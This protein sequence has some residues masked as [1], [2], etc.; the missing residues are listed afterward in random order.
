MGPEERDPQFLI[1]GHYLEKCEDFD[2]AGKRVL[3]SRLGYRISSSFVHAFFGRVFNHPH[4]VFTDEMLRPELQ[5]LDVFADGMD[6][7][8]TTQKRVAEMYFED[9]SIG[10]AC[11]PLR[12]LLH[13]MREDQW[14]GKNLAHPELRQLFTREALLGSDWYAA[15]LAAKQQVDRR[16]WWRHMDYLDRFLKKS[17]YAD[18]AARLGIAGRLAHA[19]KTADEVESPAYLD[20]LRGTL[21]AE[22]IQAY[23]KQ[24]A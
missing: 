22:P 10:Q 20:R 16:L 14:E 17:S 15:R 6:N 18:E 1:S 19:R 12:A 13:V 24:T 5:D 4:A 11:P 7:I 8:V 9:G 23:L 21:G 3:A 2:H